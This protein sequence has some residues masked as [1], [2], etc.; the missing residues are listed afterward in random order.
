[1]GTIKAV[2]K[3]ENP[4]E[5]EQTFHIWLDTNKMPFIKDPDDTATLARLHPIPFLV[6]IPEDKI[7][8]KMPEKLQ[9]EALGILAWMVSGA[10]EWYENKLGKPQEVSGARD[11]WRN[12]QVDPWAGAVEY[13]AKKQHDDYYQYENMLPYFRTSIPTV[14]E[15]AL[16]FKVKDMGAHRGDATRVGKILKKIGMIK[17]GQNGRAQVR[18]YRFPPK[19][20]DSPATSP[21][22]AHTEED[23]DLLSGQ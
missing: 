19:K 17:D 9:K 4:I 15:N 3:F 10:R 8:Q 23:P 7:D 12:S 1:M 21:H 2:R 5:F 16:G 20:D 13:W 18:M 14:M 6:Q 11:E 22:T